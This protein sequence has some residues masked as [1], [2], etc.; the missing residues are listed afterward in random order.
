MSVL[1]PRAVAAPLVIAALVVLAVPA[2]AHVT[3]R[4][5]DPSA[6]GF[7]VYTVRVPN[8]RDDAATVKVQV[9]MPEGFEASR[10]QPHPGWTLTLA[11]GVL[12]AEGGE[13]GPGQFDE[14]R[15][16]ARN[17][18]E[19]TEL[20]FPALQTYDDGEVVEWIGEPDADEPAAVVKIVA[21]EDP[22]ADAAAASP[23]VVAA[24]ALGALGALAGGAA[25][26]R[27]RS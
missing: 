25:L 15:F 22:R 9:Q 26:W 3:V 11:D 14:F 16:Q 8:E 5:D 12:V 1:S 13:I 23:M 21:E 20:R 24:L 6:G 19:P 27:S 2:L 7:A 10:Y 18:E 17:P 4:T